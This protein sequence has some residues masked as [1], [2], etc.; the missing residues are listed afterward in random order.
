MMAWRSASRSS[1]V[2]C[3]KVV[4]ARLAAATASSTS[5]FVPSEIVPHGSSVDGLITWW[6]RAV[7]GATQD[8]LM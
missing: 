4:N 8:P 3:E 2:V 6:S 7:F 1:R 5:A